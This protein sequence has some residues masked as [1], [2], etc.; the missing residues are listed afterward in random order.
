MIRST[1][2][3]MLVAATLAGTAVADDDPLVGDRPDFTESAVTIAP[4]RVQVEAGATFYADTGLTYDVNDDL[5]LD[6]RVGRGFND[7]DEDR[8]AGLGLVVRR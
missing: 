2:A 8:F 4:G 3:A 1:I 7:L 5:Q 6:L